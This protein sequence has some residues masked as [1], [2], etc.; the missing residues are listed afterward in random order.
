MSLDIKA[1]LSH[2][3]I[4]F[5]FGSFAIPIKIIKSQLKGSYKPETRLICYKFDIY[6]KTHL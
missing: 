6:I 5:D 3:L 2:I 4:W 1:D